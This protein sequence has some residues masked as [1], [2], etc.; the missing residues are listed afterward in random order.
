LL[1]LLLVGFCCCLALNKR[2]GLKR[3]LLI[4]D[5]EVS[6][7]TELLGAEL[8]GFVLEDPVKLLEDVA[9]LRFFMLR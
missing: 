1:L 4:D 3:S 7:L 9:R 2:A 8:F 5:E 6:L